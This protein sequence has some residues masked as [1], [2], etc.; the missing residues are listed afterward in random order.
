MWIVKGEV[1]ELMA[2]LLEL[3]RELSHGQE[4]TKYLLNVVGYVVCF[5][6]HFQHQVGDIRIGFSKPRMLTV[7]LIPEDQAKGMGHKKEALPLKFFFEKNVWQ[8]G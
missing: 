8:C 5:L 2:F 4:K 7:E 3:L 1:D 6:T